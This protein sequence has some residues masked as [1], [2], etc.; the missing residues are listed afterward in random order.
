M[1]ATFAIVVL[2]VQVAQQQ[3]RIDELAAEMHGSLHEQAMSARADKGAHVIQLTASSGAGRAEVVM[4]PDGTGYFTDH[5]LPA[6]PHGST[7]QLLA[8]VGDPASPRM[9]S[10]GVLGA[11]PGTT[12]FRLAAP[13]IMFKVTTES[14]PGGVTPGDAVVM[15]GLVA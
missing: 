3:D 2:G 4:L 9:V 1:A 6:L 8:K 5:D 12:A 14:M 13:T 15:S 10:L 7:Y 11:D